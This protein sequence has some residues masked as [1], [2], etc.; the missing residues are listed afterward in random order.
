MAQR[1]LHHL[2]LGLK[3]ASQIDTGYACNNACR[4][5]NQAL[6]RASEEPTIPSDI[7][8]KIDAA[9]EHPET[10]LVFVGGES[11]VH[12]DLPTWIERAKS[13]GI[14]HIILQTNGRMLAYHQYSDSLVEAGCNIFAVSLQGATA[15]CHDFLTQSPGSFKQTIRGIR[16]VRDAG[17]TVWVNT[18]I[19]RPNFRHLSEIV[20]RC[21]RLGV[22][23]IRFVWPRLEGEAVAQSARIIPNM[24]MVIPFLEAARTLGTRLGRRIL[25]EWPAA[26]SETSV[27][28]GA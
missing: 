22:S 10:P 9:L 11:T 2:V 18:V 20:T 6:L 3:R 27:N 23:R 8:E 12:P 14:K 5:C 7:D 13:G 19:T 15:A 28:V 1:R 17:A 16:N 4:F 25:V 21:H 24:E 26:P